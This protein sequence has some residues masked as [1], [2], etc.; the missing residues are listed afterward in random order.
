MASPLVLRQKASDD[1][2]ELVAYYLSEAGGDVAHPSK[3]SERLAYVYGDRACAW[4]V[5]GTR[6]V[7]TSYGQP[8]PTLVGFWYDH[9]QAE[10]L[11]LP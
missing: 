10:G 1:V 2:D 7:P 8:I 4:Q 5:N 9:D 11:R 6:A 3:R